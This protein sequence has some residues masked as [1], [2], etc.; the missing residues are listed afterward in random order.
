MYKSGMIVVWNATCTNISNMFPP[1]FGRKCPQ[2]E[3]RQ[4]LPNLSMSN[5]IQDY[6]ASWPK[7][8]MVIEDYN[9]NNVKNFS[10][11]KKISNFAKIN[12]K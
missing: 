2:N 12:S 11:N 10:L 9:L 8:N 5:C 3:I 1:K 7:T 6:T 4:G